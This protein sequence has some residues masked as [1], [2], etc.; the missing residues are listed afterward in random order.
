MTYSLFFIIYIALSRK[1]T[2]SENIRSESTDSLK[3]RIYLPLTLQGPST[4]FCE[5]ARCCRLW[6]VDTLKISH[7][8][9]DPQPA[10]SV[11]GLPRPLPRRNIWYTYVAHHEPPGEMRESAANGKCNIWTCYQ[12]RWCVKDLVIYRESRKAGEKCGKSKRNSSQESGAKEGEGGKEN[13]QCNRAH[14]IPLS[15][16][17]GPRYRK[18]IWENG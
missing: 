5:E 10:A 7:N 4:D 13:G 15:K 14:V 18:L 11:P 17:S 16:T 6:G 12:N 9:S 1:D 2:Q 3:E 8:S